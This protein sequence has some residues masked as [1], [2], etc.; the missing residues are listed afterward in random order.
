MAE[1]V[2]RDRAAFPTRSA[3]CSTSGTLA[4]WPA[5]DEGPGAARRGR[6][7][8]RGAPNVTVDCAALTLKSG[9]AI[10]PAGSSYAARSNA[11]LAARCPGGR[12][13]RPG[14]PRGRGALDEGDRSELAELATADGLVDLIIPR[15]GEGLKESLKSVATVPVMY[16]AAGNC[17]VYVHAD[18]DLEMARRVAFNAKVDRP[19]CATRRR[20]CSSD[21]AVADLFLPGILGDLREA[22]VELMG[23]ERSARRRVMPPLA[24]RPRRI[25]TP[26]TSDMRMTVGSWILSTDAIAHVN[27]HGTGHSEAIVTS[28]TMRPGVHGRSR[29]GGRLRER[30]DAIHRRV[31][32]R[33]G[34]RDREL[35]PEASRARADRASRADHVQ[36]R[37]P[38]RRPGPE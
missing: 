24:R 1:G 11:A 20:R 26:S 37:R 4:Q 30:V 3:S 31:R 28:P 13:R 16:A 21:A 17:H 8:L 14:C 10:V 38:G 35:D 7:G 29:C 9:N 5:A 36:V 12:G 23:D 18:A 6:R 19:G 33:D 25:G 22:G 34:G 2:R 27:A 15:G 32:V